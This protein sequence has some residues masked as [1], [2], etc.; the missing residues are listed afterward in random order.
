MLKISLSANKLLLAFQNLK[1]V[2]IPAIEISEELSSQ[3]SK[4]DTQKFNNLNESI[5]NKL[6]FENNIKLKNVHF[7]YSGTSKKV[8]DGINL[9]I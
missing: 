9:E 3:Y 6:K 2:K 1:S 7:T 8:L 4:I 5:E